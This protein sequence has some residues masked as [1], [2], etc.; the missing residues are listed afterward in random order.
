MQHRRLL[1]GRPQ[2]LLLRRAAAAQSGR[3]LVQRVQ[4][5]EALA[6]LQRLPLSRARCDWLGCVL[7]REVG[8]LRRANTLQHRRR[9]LVQRVQRHEALAGLQRLPHSRARCDWLGCVLHREV[10]LLRRANALQHRRLLLGRLQTLLLRRA[11]AAQSG[12][13]LVQRVQRHEA[14]A[15]LQRLPHSR[16]RCDWLGRV[17]HR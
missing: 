15:G 7:H 11:D 16:A 2:D 14:L 3:L 1:L 13:L 17:L 8:L 12:R 9:L 5:H 6:G 10:G 4:R